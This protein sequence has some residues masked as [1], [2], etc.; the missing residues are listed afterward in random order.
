MAG[1]WFCLFP[2]IGLVLL[3]V[4]GCVLH[5]AGLSLLSP[6][7]ALAFTAGRVASRQ[8]VIAWVC[9]SLYVVSALPWFTPT[10]HLLRCFL[11]LCPKSVSV[12]Q[13]PVVPGDPQLIES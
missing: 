13:T 8:P 5:V 3:M 12:F 10:F 6:A 7:Q 2:Y 1:Q 4:K 9:L 11:S